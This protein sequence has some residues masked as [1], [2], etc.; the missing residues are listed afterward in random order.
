MANNGTTGHEQELVDVQ[1]LKATL[2]KFKDEKVVSSGFLV[3]YNTST[4]MTSLTPI[5][6][7]TAAY[8]TTTGMIALTF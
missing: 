1:D 7:A 2:Q 4:G 3:A 8:N 5:G 6:G